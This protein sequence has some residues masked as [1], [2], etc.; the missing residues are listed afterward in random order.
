MR[1]TA[2][3]LLLTFATLVSGATAAERAVDPDRLAFERLQALA[4]SKPAYDTAVGSE[5]ARLVMGLWDHPIYRH[6]VATVLNLDGGF[7][8]R[9]FNRATL[10]GEGEREDLPNFGT[11]DGKLLRGG[12]PTAAGFGKLRDLGVRTVVN[13]RYEEPDEALTVAGLGMRYLYLPVPDTDRPADDQIARFLAL[14]REPEAAKIYVHCAWG[15]N[16]TA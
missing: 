11:V 2:M 5:V 13:L 16:R 7:L 9:I 3:S 12:Q 8:D 15:V 1:H 14:Q 6:P 4:A 10:E